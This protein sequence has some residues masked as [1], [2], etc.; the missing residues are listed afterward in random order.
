MSNTI[1]E[2]PISKLFP[3]SWPTRCALGFQPRHAEHSATRSSE[4]A[5]DGR[6]RSPPR[7]RSVRQKATTG[8]HRSGARHAW[9]GAAGW[10][11]ALTSTSTFRAQARTGAAVGSLL[12]MPD[13]VHSPL[14][15][16]SRGLRARS[17]L[18]RAEL[19]ARA[20]RSRGARST[21]L[22]AHVPRTTPITTQADPS[23]VHRP[24]PRP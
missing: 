5:L 10:L 1:N 12:G 2:K 20:R 19:G 6:T 8:G 9:L 11:D 3:T 14:A 15:L 17:R 24:L 22:S 7:A 23:S 13:L 4:R 16:R 21:R 18:P